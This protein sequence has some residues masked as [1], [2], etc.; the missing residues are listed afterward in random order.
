MRKL[1]IQE[2]IDCFSFPRCA[3]E[4]SATASIL[5][6]GQYADLDRGDVDEGDLAV[7]AGSERDVSAVAAG[8][9]LGIDLSPALSVDQDFGPDMAVGGIQPTVDLPAGQARG[10]S[11]GDE[12]IGEIPA[13]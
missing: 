9:D 7:F 8:A 12:A 3:C 6:R 4:E 5:F 11:T 10:P 2:R 13:P 1:G